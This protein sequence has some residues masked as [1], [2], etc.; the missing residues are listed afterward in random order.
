MTT[1]VTSERRR[2]EW[3]EWHA[4][5]ESLAASEHGTASLTGTHWLD[6]SPV[7]IDGLPGSWRVVDGLVV[8][9]Q[10]DVSLSPS[11]EVVLDGK[12]LRAIV[13][14]GDIALRVFDPAA[15]GRTTF[16]GIDVFDLRD[17]WIVTGRFTEAAPE[18]TIA[19]DHVGGR[20]SDDALAGT[21]T[22]QILGHEVELVA[23]PRE[24]GELQVTFADTSNGDTTQQ[25]RFLNLP[26]PDVDGAVTIDLNRAYL[27]PCAFSDHYLCPI[28]PAA[29]RLPFAV[30]AGERSVQR[31]GS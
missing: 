2:A 26:R 11:Q 14:A 27:P 24:G 1:T 13:N 6:E 19:I 16:A 17:E 20:R 3:R 18:S 21:V 15:P 30:H 5:R 31:S 4:A 7:E 10:A 12:L 23:F 8:G 25:F 29:N 9:A 28:P 22:A